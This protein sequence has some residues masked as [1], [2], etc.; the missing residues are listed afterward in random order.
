[1]HYLLAW[2]QQLITRTV[3]HV[4]RRRVLLSFCEGGD[5]DEPNCKGNGAISTANLPG[6]V[7]GFPGNRGKCSAKRVFI[8]TG[9]FRLRCIGG[10]PTQRTTASECHWEEGLAHER[11]D[12][13]GGRSP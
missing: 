13:R 6:F 9:P 2:I 3:G 8:T 11:L 10:T 4:T 12:Y 1:M 5:I 7:E